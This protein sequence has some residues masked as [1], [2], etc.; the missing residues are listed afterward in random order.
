[1]KKSSLIFGIIFLIIFSV[2]VIADD[3]SSGLSN[4]FACNSTVDNKG[5]GSLSIIR[6]ALVN[7][8]NGWGVD[9]K[10]CRLPLASSASSNMIDINI[11]STNTSCWGIGY[12]LNISDNGGGGY[13]PMFQTKSQSRSMDW[14]SYIGF[15]DGGV[16]R[17]KFAFLNGSTFYYAIN[18]YTASMINTSHFFYIE[19]N[20]T[21]S[22]KLYDNG[23]LAYS[24]N[25]FL[26]SPN[27][28]VLE[29]GNGS[30]VGVNTP[31]SRVDEIYFYNRCLATSEQLLLAQYALN[32]TS[33]SFTSSTPSST[34]SFTFPTPA[35]GSRNNTQIMIN[36]SCTPSANIDLFFDTS[37]PPTTKVISNQTSPIIYTT[38]VS[39]DGLYY[40]Y[41]S[42]IA[43]SNSTINT[44]VYDTTSPQIL[45]RGANFFGQ[46]NGSNIDRTQANKNLSFNLTDNLQVYGFSVNITNSSRQTLYYEINTTILMPS[47]SI[48]RYINF[49]NWTRGKYDVNIQVA[50]THTSL[51][52]PVYAISDIMTQEKITDEKLS[53][54]YGKEYL[55]AQGNNIKIYTDKP[56][57]VSTDKEV[58][59]YTFGF[60]FE[61]KI[62]SDKLFYIKCDSKLTYIPHDIYKGHF[63]C[64]NGLKGNWIDFEGIEGKPI[65]KE[66]DKNTY[67]I[68]FENLG[69]EMTV[70]SIGGLN[71][72]SVNYNFDLVDLEAFSI[73]AKNTQTNNTIPD[74]NVTYNG[75]TYVASVSKV[76]LPN[77]SVVGYLNFSATAENYS[78]QTIL[79]LAVN[80]TINYTVYF[81]A[82]PYILSVSP[83][84]NFITTENNTVP[85]SVNIQENG[86]T[87]AYQWFKDSVLQAI[88]STWSWV[89]G[90]HD[91]NTGNPHTITVIINSSDGTQMTNTW[92]ANVT[93]ANLTYINETPTNVSWLYQQ[94]S[95]YCGLPA[96]ATNWSVNMSVQFSD[97]SAIWYPINYSCFGSCNNY[98][99]V[100]NITTTPDYLGKLSFRCTGYD[101][102][103]TV[104][105]TDVNSVNVYYANV[106]PSNPKTMKPSKGIYDTTIQIICSGAESASGAEVFYDIKADYKINATERIETF[107]DANGTGVYDWYVLNLP[108]QDNITYA[109]RA[110]DGADYSPWV[111]PKVNLSIRHGLNLALFAS[112]L[113]KKYT[114]YSNVIS[115][116]YCSSEGLS[117]TEIVGVWADCNNDAQWDY[118]N[119]DYE[120]LTQMT[121]VIVRRV[122]DLFTCQYTSEGLKQITVGCITKNINDS[123]VSDSGL[124]SGISDKCNLQKTYTINVEA[125]E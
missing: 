21:N 77:I 107:L 34:P 43:G 125:D 26:F 82:R 83:A 79:N 124:C 36:A 13:A 103:T 33:Y 37:N 106:P 101:G 86:F 57:E 53:I 58:D 35:N 92:T 52:E 1:M 10:Y 42:C 99:Y 8:S 39:S 48:V 16:G 23:N 122:S 9:N 41:A 29:F 100:A 14:F 22:M 81:D 97:E 80:N 55:T 78:P 27:H 63:V 46:A 5:A 84:N 4:Y 105:Q 20:I 88:T 120:N 93:N 24:N 70:K 11:N 67:S 65:I 69:S 56:A 108:N 54:V 15:T 104:T 89:V 121:G 119:F 117:N 111:Y 6:N 74:F 49:S 115:T 66:I 30:V 38:S 75:L 62:V 44:W 61:E 68:L 95:F 12:L 76:I 40:Y 47:I 17:I 2:S 31:T 118:S 73:L 94:I 87:M 64:A 110:Y 116:V 25:T 109:C 91:A 71:E 90:N 3:L 98:E 28:D 123:R 112:N 18:G 102:A 50:D 96:P 7:V 32:K 85:F 45:L 114:P 113:Y 51:S 59:R 19:I 60:I 72:N